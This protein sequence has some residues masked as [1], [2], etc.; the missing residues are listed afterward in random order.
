MHGKH[1]A[2]HLDSW[3]KSFRWSDIIYV[4]EFWG[5]HVYNVQPS[6]ELYDSLRNSRLPLDPTSRSKLPEVIHWL[7]VRAQHSGTRHD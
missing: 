3:N 2:S 7:G 5:F 4:G 6:M 1:S